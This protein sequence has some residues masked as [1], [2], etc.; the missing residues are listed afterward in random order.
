[1]DQAP[2]CGYLLRRVPAGGEC[3]SHAWDHKRQLGLPGVAVIV[4]LTIGGS[5]AR[6]AGVLVAV[7][8]GPALLDEYFTFEACS[9]S[10][11]EY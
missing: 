3:L 2:G 5:M 9:Q 7:P 4:A 10:S 1:M 11:T 6:I 8:T